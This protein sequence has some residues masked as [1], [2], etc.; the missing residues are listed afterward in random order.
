MHTH[1]IQL[2]C[3]FK[4]TLTECLSLY[5][6]RQRERNQPGWQK[7]FIWH[8]S[9]LNSRFIS[10]K[11][12]LKIK[13]VMQSN[14]HKLVIQ[15]QISNI[16][17]EITCLNQLSNFRSPGKAWWPIKTIFRKSKL[18]YSIIILTNA[19]SDC[20]AQLS[21]LQYLLKKYTDYFTFCF[22]TGK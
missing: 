10:L 20:V 14:T 1:T 12:S 6:E 16:I 4:W 8:L 2:L 3:P 5:S 17:F 22:E 18:I 15:F 13:I 7:P 21:F 9:E 11:N 19:S